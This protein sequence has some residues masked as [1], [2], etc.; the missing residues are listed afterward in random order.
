M[1]NIFDSKFTDDLSDEQVPRSIFSYVSGSKSKELR[2]ITIPHLLAECVEK[3]GSQ[4]AFVVPFQQVR[5][6]WYDFQN[7]VNKIAAGLL[8][9][10][11]NKGDR[12][13]IWSPNC[14]EWVGIQF[15]TASIGAILVNINPAYKENELLY[16]L[17]KVECKL[18]ITAVS[19]NKFDFISILK[20]TFLELH[21]GYTHGSFLENAP[22]LK[23]I[24]VLSKDAKIGFPFFSDLIRNAGISHLKRLQRISDS[25]DPDDPINIQF[26]SG[27]TGSPKAAT[28]THYNIVNNA[29]FCADS[30]G[31]S[32]SDRLCLPVPLYHCFGMVLGVLMAVSSGAATVFPSPTFDAHECISVMSKERCT[33]VHG[34]PTMF[35]AMLEL[36]RSLTFDFSNMR[37]GIMAG[38]PCPEE[39]MR[40]VINDLQISQITIAYGMTET[41]PVSF[42]SSTDDPLDRRVSTVGR[43]QPHAEVK[44]IDVDGKIVEL[45]QQ[46]ELCTRGYLVMQG[47][48]GDE[49]A[50]RDS[51][52][53]A[54]WMHTGDLATI[55]Q[56]GYCSIVG[57]VKDMLIRGGENIYPKEI[58]EVLYQHPQVNDAQVFGVPDPKYGEIVAAW[59]IPKDK[60]NLTS[61]NI[62]EFC[63]NRTAHYKIPTHI[64]FVNE[65][66]L[67]AT[68]K[69]QK[70][71]M[72]KLMMEEL[73][74]H[75]G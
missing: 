39:V 73:G 10:G 58:E 20:K 27:T 49:L 14:I 36:T 57:R 61:E 72:K 67:T 22:S 44:I 15:A 45:G 64:K 5:Y 11:I 4:E 55:D 29:I 6:S 40:R 12:V 9:Y 74:I 52:D 2:F 71:V 69:P 48:W 21:S 54:G 62:I 26:T 28:L 56:E 63:K 37:T 51:I 35:I 18:L 53:S 31:F 25:L 8:S 23:S 34:V 33:A 50:T 30:M 65:F 41:S 43:I 3:F 68:G 60:F 46:G 38:A 17:N 66:P 19:H 32:E 24:F 42:Q 75:Y 47:Y 16:A 59:I 1:K 7:Y 13:A 70:F